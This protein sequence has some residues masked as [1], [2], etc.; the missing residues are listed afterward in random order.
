MDDI[1]PTGGF[2]KE[3]LL[4]LPFGCSCLTAVILFLLFS[5][6]VSEI[7]PEVIF[8]LEELKMIYIYPDKNYKYHKSF[9]TILHIYYLFLLQLTHF[10]F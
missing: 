7:T 2:G 10:G 4:G 8:S 5:S 1:T 6:P 3:L 9:D